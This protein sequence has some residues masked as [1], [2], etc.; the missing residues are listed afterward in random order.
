MNN[1]EERKQEILLRLESRA[2]ETQQDYQKEY[3]R[4]SDLIMENTS[5][6]SDV[7][8]KI[9]KLEKKQSELRELYDM[10]FKKDYAKY[11]NE[12]SSLKS[13]EKQLDTEFMEL[14]KKSTE[15]KKQAKS[16]GF[17]L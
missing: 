15:L 7:K 10:K 2:L 5:E 3:D 4:L 13:K 9:K 14:D 11:E 1:F 16:K 12:I 6:I 17:R 8:N